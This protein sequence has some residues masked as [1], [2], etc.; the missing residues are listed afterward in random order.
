[1]GVVQ[2]LVLRR[3]FCGFCGA[4]FFV[5]RDCERGQRYCGKDCSTKARRQNCRQYNRDYQETMQ[6]R[7]NHAGRQ[8]AYLWRRALARPSNKVTDHSLVRRLFSGK[9]A[10]EQPEL[11]HGIDCCR[12]CG[13]PGIVN[14]SAP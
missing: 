5:C 14:S 2:R 11:A 3:G 6:G 13:R 9:L 12:F 8:K 7:L 4:M 10:P 1:M